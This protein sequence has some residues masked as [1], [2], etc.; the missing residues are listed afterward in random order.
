NILEACQIIGPQ[1]PR[2]DKIRPF[3][4]HPGFIEA[5]ADN[6][7]SALAQ[8]PDHKRSR[9][10]IVFTAHSI[11]QSMDDAC[12]YA[13]QMLEAC[14]LFSDAAGCSPRWHLAYQS[15]SG[16]PSQ[17]WLE[18]DIL[19]YIR[20][21]QASGGENLVVCPIGFLS[22]HMEVVYDLDN[23]AKNLSTALGVNLVRART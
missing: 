2:I 11:P 22:D 10:R 5:N 6:L 23:E 13:D 15:R 12:P 21:F 17:P 16:P 7:C 4:N 9:A 8:I 18:P 14:R 1:A 3:F 20:S 19:D